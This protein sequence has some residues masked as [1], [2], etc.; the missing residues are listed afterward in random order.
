MTLGWLAGQPCGNGGYWISQPQPA[1]YCSY[2][3]ILLE[4]K[5]REGR[6]T[7]AHGSRTSRRTLRRKG[8]RERAAAAREIEW[9]IMAGVSEG[10]A[11]GEEAH[12][13]EKAMQL[14]RRIYLAMRIVY[15]RVEQSK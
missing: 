12:E 7:K 14:Y 8:E 3:Y 11:R 15:S 4:K 13:I 9:G 10:R 1:S 5:E 2:S 6:E